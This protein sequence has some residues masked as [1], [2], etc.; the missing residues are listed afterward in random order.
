MNINPNSWFMRSFMGRGHPNNYIDESDLPKT[1]CGLV[2]KVLIQTLKMALIL[3]ITAAS[4]YVALTEGGLILREHPIPFEGMTALYLGVPA[5]IGHIVAA[6]ALGLSIIGVCILLPFF[7]AIEWIKDTLYERKMAKRYADNL[8]PEQEKKP[9]VLVEIASAM[10]DRV[11]NK[12]CVL[13][14]YDSK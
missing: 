12:T 4:V 14:T 1:F 7:T 8:S 11:K 6:S 5:L 2:W 3:Y 10:Y 9:N 13:L